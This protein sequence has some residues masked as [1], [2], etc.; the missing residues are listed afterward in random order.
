MPGLRHQGLQSMLTH[1]RKSELVQRLLAA[2]R[3][4]SPIPPF[5]DATPDLTLADAYEVQ[6]RLVEAK[7]RNGAEVIGWKAG[8]T[9]AAMREQ[10][11]VA[12]PNYGCLLDSVLVQGDLRIEELIR[13]RIEPEV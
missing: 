6:R 7:V 10:M 4:R 3:D 2:E 9:S 1:E 12:A 5:T 11:G 13:P 8:F